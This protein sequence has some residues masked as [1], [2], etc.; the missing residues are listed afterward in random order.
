MKDFLRISS[1]VAASIVSASAVMFLVHPVNDSPG[2]NVVAE[3]ALLV[4]LLIL[5]GQV[6]LETWPPELGIV[7]IL[8]GL[9]WIWVLLKVIDTVLSSIESEGIPSLGFLMALAFIAFSLLTTG[10]RS[11]FDH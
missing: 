3:F 9:G 6:F 7:S 1:G 10:T 11:F 5:V 4:T 2:I 8:A